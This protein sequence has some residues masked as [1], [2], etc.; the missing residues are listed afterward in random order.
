MVKFTNSNKW[1]DVWFSQLTM[2]QKVM[3]IYLCDICDIAGFY[4]VNER[5]VSLR[6]GIEDVRGAVESLS[7]AIIIKG[8][9][10]WIKKHLKHQRNLPINIRNGAHKSILNS[11][12]DQIDRFPELLDYLPI[13]DG[14]LVRK[15]LKEGG[16]G[17][18]A[19][20]REGRPP[21]SNSNSISKVKEEAIK[22][23]EEIKNESLI[24][25]LYK[26]FVGEENLMGQGITTGT[27]EILAEAIGVM[28]VEE[29]K[30]YCDARLSDEFKASPEKFFL[31][32]GWRRYQDV[33]KSKKDENKRAESRRREMRERE[34]IPNEEAPKEFKEFVKNFGKRSNTIKT[35]SSTTS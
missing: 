20:P 16:R 24:A 10:I 8:N 15:Y 11:I 13:P 28:D 17:G 32:D 6:T 14:E 31:K 34:S 18:G 1:D 12:R 23:K 29:W 30:I 2:E 22:E 26:Y 35:T 27:R 9:W 25:I 5:L 4:E 33:A 19:S 21:L 3:F 7:K